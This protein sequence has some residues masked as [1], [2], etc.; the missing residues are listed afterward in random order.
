LSLPLS[1]NPTDGA[2]APRAKVASL[3]HDP[4]E[5]EQL[6]LLDANKIVEAVRWLNG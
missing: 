4:L 2:D 1:R 6:T 5:L 3:T